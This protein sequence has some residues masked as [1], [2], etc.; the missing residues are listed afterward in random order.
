MEAMPFC[1]FT[2]DNGMDV[3]LHENHRLPLIGINLWFHVGSKNE[4]LKRNGLAHFVEHLMFQGL[5]EGV[6]FIAGM[7]KRGGRF[8]NGSTNKDRTNY[9]E[10]LPAEKIWDGLWEEARRMAAMATA[11]DDEMVERQRRV[12]INERLES[13]E[14]QPLALASELIDSLLFGPEHPYHWPVLGFMPHIENVTRDELS[15]FFQDFYHPANASLCVAGHLDWQ[16]TLDYIAKTFGTIP[17]GPKVQ[18][19]Q[20]PAVQHKAAAWLSY[21]DRVANPVLSMTW[22]APSM[23]DPCSRSTFAWAMALADGALGRL[24]KFKGLANHC[25]VSYVALELGGRFSVHLELASGQD[26][27]AAAASVQDLLQKPYQLGVTESQLLHAHHKLQYREA[28]QACL[29]GGMGSRS[30]QL[31][32]RNIFFSD[33]GREEEIDSAAAMATGLSFFQG[34]PVV[35]LI[36]PGEQLLLDDD[37]RQLGTEK[38]AQAVLSSGPG[39]ASGLTRNQP[40]PPKTALPPLRELEVDT[41]QLGN[42]L[43]WTHVHYDD[44]PILEAGLLLFGGASM[45]PPY[46]A[47]LSRLWPQVLLASLREPDRARAVPVSAKTSGSWDAVSFRY[48][49]M[50][51]GLGTVLESLSQL[52][53]DQPVDP[54]HWS[55]EL[56]RSKAILGRVKQSAG[57]AAQAGLSSLLYPLSHPYGQSA[58]GTDSSLSRLSF[59]LIKTTAAARLRPNAAEI[60]VV[61]ALDG[62]DLETMLESCFDR[63]RPSEAQ[64]A[65]K[66]RPVAE[67]ASQSPP[68]VLY[69]IPGALQ[70]FI[71]FGCRIPAR[72]H[73]DFLLLSVFNQAFGG[74]Y[75]TPFNLELRERRGLVY[76]ARTRL[77]ARRK[78]SLFLGQVSV[79]VDKAVDAANTVLKLCANIGSGN[80]VTPSDVEFA[81]GWMSANLPAQYETP[82]LIANQVLAAREFDTQAFGYQKIAQ[83][84][85]GMRY[86]DVIAAA[87]RHIDISGIRMVVAGDLSRLRE[88]DLQ[89]TCERRVFDENLRLA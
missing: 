54:A 59:E 6:D 27:N 46:A 36:T 61:G 57:A 70:A 69:D 22:A 35:V 37:P 64:D 13:V 72:R 1:K 23:C 39:F 30:D 34:E 51:D 14:H 25:D 65:V 40:Q 15:A 9:F 43:L 82:H 53:L 67:P 75:N 44:M 42:G 79:S 16:K 26:A 4:S 12:I 83:I 33:P 20:A 7:Q 76:D 24:L 11:I 48:A 52:C 87:A 58:F 32:A 10:T 28:Y 45:D 77:E 71:C 3:I 78:A 85:R 29:I 89:S 56:G 50:G 66:S 47:G 17:A 60:V 5:D 81:K 63:W 80:A 62:N 8:V 38:P 84:L 86:E 49:T 18:P 31:N 74:L 41:G 88:E 2:L 55:S 68:V 21:T 19:M 73:P